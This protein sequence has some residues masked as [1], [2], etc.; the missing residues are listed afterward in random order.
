MAVGRWLACVQ[1]DG[2]RI[3]SGSSDNTVRIYDHATG[4]EVG[5]LHG[6]TNLVRTVQAGFG[7]FPGAADDLSFQARA[8]EDE[9]VE[10]VRTGAI[11]EDIRTRHS[12]A[13]KTAVDNANQIRSFGAKRR[14]SFGRRT[15]MGAGS[16]G[17]AC[18]KRRLFVLVQLLICEPTTKAGSTLEVRQPRL[19]L[20]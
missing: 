14:L 5:I 11:V 18:D 8:A 4:A 13:R 1:S 2:K 3:V 20:V 16:W 6:H 15:R 17:T 9:Y 19:W 12:S 10:G 7:D